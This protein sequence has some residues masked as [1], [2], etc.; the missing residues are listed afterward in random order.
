MHFAVDGHTECLQLFGI[1]IIK[2]VHGKIP[3]GR[4]AETTTE[5]GTRPHHILISA[6]VAPDLPRKIK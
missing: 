6:V 1:E 2:A 3:F 4:K 5:T